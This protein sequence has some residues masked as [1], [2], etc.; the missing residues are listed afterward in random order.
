M[1]EKYFSYE[2]CLIMIKNVFIISDSGTI[3]EKSAILSFSVIT[4]RN[5]MEPLEDLDA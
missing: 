1:L 3:S 2:F 4:L 5:A